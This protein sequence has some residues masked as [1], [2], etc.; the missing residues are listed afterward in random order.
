MVEDILTFLNDWM[1][2]TILVAALLGLG[3]WFSIKLNFAQFTYIPEMFRVLF[4]KR[5][6]SAEGKKG[7]SPFQAFAI[8]TASR[9]GT[10]NLAGVAAAITVGGPG[11]VFW[12]WIVAILGGA[13]SFIESTLAQIYKVPEEKQYRGGPAYY[14]EK[15]L[16]N[17]GLGIVFAITITFTYGLVFSSV[18]SNTIRLAF[19]NSFDMDKWLLGGILTF[20][21][22]IIIFGGL[23]RIAQVTQFIIPIMAIFY[24]ILAAYV[25]VV[26]IGQVP[27]M[28]G[29]IFAGAFG[30][31]EVAGGTFGGMILIGIK[32]GLF[33]NEA[34]MGSAPNA[35]ATSEVTHPV[36]QGLI[37]TLGVFTDTLLICSATAVIILFAGD[38]VGTDLDGIQLTQEAF[39][40][41]LGAWAAVFIAIAIFLFAFSSIIGN[42]YYGETNIEFIKTSK[43]A[44]FIY[45]VAVLFMVMFG[46]I[47]EFGLVWSLADLTMGIM[48]LI[49][50]YAIF[51]LSSVAYA[52]LQDYRKQKKAGKDPV[53]Y[54]DHLPGVDGMEYWRRDQTSE[55]E[56]G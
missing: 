49:N 44:I 42:Y 27:T 15:G 3:L 24:I 20:I 45:R 32:R 9:V 39:E 37:Q 31:R 1:W 14:I 26:N 11:A 8:S 23:K 4:D 28:F 50:L 19:E 33:S 55:K 43:P 21:V 35:A 7:T 6:I 56:H 13:S 40:S 48:A 25:L 34:G 36:K 51:R 38:Y 30:F 17:R 2:G 53:F 10:G 46:A 47:A 54:Q 41:E 5:S 52:A 22:A 12:M 29:Q 18:Q 16:K